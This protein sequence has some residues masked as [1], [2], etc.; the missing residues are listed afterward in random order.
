MAHCITFRQL[1]RV[2]K[3]IWIKTANTTSVLSGSKVVLKIITAF[4]SLMLFLTSGFD[5]SYVYGIA[6]DNF[7][8]G[9]MCYI[10]LNGLTL[11]LV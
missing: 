11:V 1:A 6:M 9:L 2:S 3:W 7:Q 8:S 5:L 4:K 10:S